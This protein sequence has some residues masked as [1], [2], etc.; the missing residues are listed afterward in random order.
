[1]VVVKD[2]WNDMELKSYIHIIKRWAWLLLLCTILG[3]CGGYLVSRLLKPTY[4]AST[5]ILVSKDVSDQ[6]SQFAAMNTQQLID[7]YV[8]LLS[9]ASV[10][11]EASRRLNY[12]IDLKNVG[13][14]QQVRE[15]PVIQITIEDSDPQQAPAIANMLVKVLIDQT[16]Q[17][18]GYMSTEE[19]LNKKI[20]EVEDKISTLS[21]QYN[22]ISDEI[23]QG[24]LKQVN[25]QITTVQDDI[26]T[27]NQE[28]NQLASLPSPNAE[29]SS[30][31]A[32]KQAQL[33]QLQ[34]LLVQYQQI[35]VNL[36]FTGK[37]ILLSGEP[38]YDL[39]LQQI[40]WALDHYQKIY[41]DLLDSLQT[42]QLAR[43]RNPTTI[44]QIEKA[45]PP[46]DPVRPRPLIYS[47]LAGIVGLVLAVGIVFIIEYVDDTLKTPQDVQQALDIPVLGYI[48]NM[49]SVSKTTNGLPVAWQI[50]SQTAEAINALRTNLEFAVAQPS[51]KTLLLLSFNEPGEGK[52][53][54]AT[55]LAVSYTQSGSRVVLL[56][57]DLQNPSVHLYFGLTNENGFSNLLADDSKTEAVG[58]KVDGLD[59]LTVI[60]SGNACPASVTDGV[61]KPNRIVKILNRL[62]KQSDVI[63][64]DAPSINITDSWVLAS[65]VDGVLLVIQSRGTH[66][67]KARH[68]LEQ[69]NR[70]KAT[71]LGAVLYHIP[72]I[73]QNLTDYY[74][75]IRYNRRFF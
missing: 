22:Q 71:I 41:L 9:S 43:L 73:P 24:Q 34:P 36:Q 40:Q 57:A 45:T 27:L 6:N 23:L 33:T 3:A 4:Q 50:P 49:Q 1:M 12:A 74:R 16:T 51:L 60:T 25:D 26:L 68:L 56:D 48:S 67:G 17:A 47:M 63:I 5:K 10:V 64:I 55:D 32:E 15:T 8:Q 29:Q 46:T 18:S 54:M 42:V 52:T 11:D 44:Y 28:I 31:L 62:K 69:L 66:P 61:T 38:V 20:T 14:V 13:R 39:H 2:E 35:L 21:T 37:P 19:G 75:R 7:T 30:Q 58:K 59:G 65:K 70:A 72:H 53:H